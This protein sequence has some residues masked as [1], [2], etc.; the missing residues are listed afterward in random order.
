MTATALSREVGIHQS[1]LSAWLRRARVATLPNLAGSAEEKSMERPTI[2]TA[3]DK[4]RILFEAAG[5]SQTQLGELLRREG[6]YEVELDQWRAALQGRTVGPSKS[7]EARRIKELER[8]LRRKDKALAEMTALAVLRK[9][10][11]AIWGDGVDD[12]DDPSA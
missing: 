1:T 3:E 8:E 12:T 4:A 9:K 7:S 5:C 11:E 2:R 6:V 10:V